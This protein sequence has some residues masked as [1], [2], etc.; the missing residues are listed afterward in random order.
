MASSNITIPLDI[1]DVEVVDIETD[2]SG[3]LH[4]H[5]C[6]TQK[7]VVCKKCEKEVV[8]QHGT[9]HEIKL[10]HLP[11]LGKPTYLHISPKRGKCPTCIGSPTM[12]QTCSWYTMRRPHTIAYDQHLVKQ[13]KGSTVQDVSQLEEIGY[14]A[15]LGA[16]ETL[17]PEKINWDEITAVGTVGIDE[18]ATKKGKKAYRAIITYRQDDGK[19]GVLAILPDRKKRV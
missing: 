13:L 8:C 11:I 1:P 16:L 14:D 19:T 7:N 12:T 6:S 15:I 17:L 3:N 10:R 5:V 4:I 2:L 9:S 18:V